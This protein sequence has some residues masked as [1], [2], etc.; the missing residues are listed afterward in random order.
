MTPAR[1][2]FHAGYRRAR[3]CIRPGAD[4]AVAPRKNAGSRGKAGQPV[5]NRAGQKLPGINVV[6]RYRAGW[7]EATDESREKSRPAAR[8]SVRKSKKAECEETRLTSTRA[9]GAAQISGG[10]LRTTPKPTRGAQIARRYLR[11]AQ[12]SFALTRLTAMR[13]YAVRTFSDDMYAPLVGLGVVR[14]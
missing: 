7:R 5:Q 2:V 9:V 14:T 3:N 11:T 10:Y 8:C 13:M 4:R 6:N 12:I 1:C